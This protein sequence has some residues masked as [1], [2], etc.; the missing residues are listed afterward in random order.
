MRRALTGLA[1]LV[2]A[3]TPA[4]HTL[5]EDVP[6]L[7]WFPSAGTVQWR[8]PLTP[9]EASDPVEGRLTTPVWYKRLPDLDVRLVGGK[10]LRL[11]E[12]RGSVLALSFWA[13]W[14]GP[15]RRELPKLQA[16]YDA[17][18]EAGLSVVAINVEEPLELAVP[19]AEDLGL[20]MPIGLFDPAMRPTLFGKVVPA[21]V[22]ADREGNIRGRWDGFEEGFE[23]EIDQLIE[24]L[25]AEERAAPVD[26]APV[27]YGA[28][29]YALRWFRETKTRIDDLTI[30][31]DESGE[32][33]ILASH[34]VMMS[35]HSSDGSTSREW[36]ADRAAGSV[37]L[38]PPHAGWI[39]AAFRPGAKQI[40]LFADGGGEPRVADLGAP[41]F[42]LVWLP[43]RY[44]AE[45]R[46]LLAGTLQGLLVLDDHASVTAR[47]E[48]FGAVAALAVARGSEEQLV[49]LETAGRLSWVDPAF[50]VARSAEAPDEPWRL[51]ADAHGGVAVASEEAVALVQGRL[52]PD[53]SAALAFATRSGRLRI[54][55]VA[56]GR[57]LFEAAW[58]DIGSLAAGDV[59]GDGRDELVVAAGKSLGLLEPVRLTPS[60]AP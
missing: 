21:L 9:G 6:Q 7:A 40:V 10:V 28:G 31:A 57:T 43:Q 1:A 27:L 45:G 37:R 3:A 42:D 12:A 38:A 5:A 19:F 8:V 32:P 17:R 48:G 25:L 13:T 18:R 56:D 34:G 36:V 55:S 60:S 26:V 33:E 50:T 44:R 54:A 29:S 22:I 53:G 2:V 20:T 47:P 39:A 52:A 4:G 35:V 24:T 51:A 49:V 41:V 11:R 30:T 15:C 59:D 16:L 23:A 58:P 46:A 14:C